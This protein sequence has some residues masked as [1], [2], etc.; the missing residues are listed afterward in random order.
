MAKYYGAIG[1]GETVETAP[2]VWE[3]QV[4]ER[5]YSG[6]VSQNIR[7]WEDGEHFHDD[8]TITNIISVLMDPYAYMNFHKIR[9]ITYMGI[10]W[11]VN[12]VEVKYPRLLLRIGGEY[13]ADERPDFAEE[14]Q[15]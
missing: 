14:I 9:Y 5:K 2:D 3:E 4:V 7:R 11:K 10:N 6:D 15:P 8:L 1:Y 12:T 13:V